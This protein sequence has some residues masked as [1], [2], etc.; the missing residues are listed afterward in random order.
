MSEDTKKLEDLPAEVET[1]KAEDAEQI[2]GGA[3]SFVG[4]LDLAGQPKQPTASGA[5]KTIAAAQTD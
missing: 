1:L 3:I 4:G 2:S 5:L